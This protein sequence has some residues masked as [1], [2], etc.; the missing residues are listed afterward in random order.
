M[1]SPSSIPGLIPI[2]DGDSSDTTRNSKIWSLRTGEAYRRPGGA[3]AVIGHNS[4]TFYPRNTFPKTR[5]RATV[6]SSPPRSHTP[7]ISTESA[8]TP[9]TGVRSHATLGNSTL[10][11]S[12]PN[13]SLP[14]SLQM[15][16]H[17]DS[18]PVSRPPPPPPQPLS[19]PTRFLSRLISGDCPAINPHRPTRL[20]GIR[21]QAKNKWYAVIIGRRT[22]VFDDW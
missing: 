16:P 17:L 18:P 2:E 15:R 9:S 19:S 8:L 4:I 5:N 13:N 7:D 11:N 1:S 21:G 20:L 10:A 14:H 12:G 22:G 3:K 6:D